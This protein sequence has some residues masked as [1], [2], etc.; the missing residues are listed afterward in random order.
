MTDF[1]AGLRQSVRRLVRTPGLTAAAILVYAL[2]IGANT[3]IFSIVYSVLLKPLPFPEPDRLVGVWQTA[4]GVNIENLNASIADYVTYREDSRT[5]A[6]SAIWSARSMSITGFQQPE[7]VDCLMATFRLLPMLGVH[8]ALG[9][10]LEEKD[11]EPGTADVILISHAYWQRRFAGDR[12]V[13]GRTI[14]ADGVRREIVGVLPPGTWLLDIGHEIVFPLRYRRS[15]VHFA[16]YNFQAIAR[17]RPG[18]TLADA[19]EDVRRM[20]ALEF[21]KFPPPPGMNLKM[22][23]DARLA[24]NLRWLRQDLTGEVSGS[25]WVVMATIGMVLLIA[26]A[27]VANLLLVRAEGRAQELTVRAALGAG[28]GHIAREL[29]MESLLLAAAGGLA[30]VAFARGALELVLRL[31]PARLPRFDQIGLD[32]TAL[33]FTFVITIAAGFGCGLP[34]LLRHLRGGLAPALRGGG[35]TLSSSRDRNLARNLLTVVQVALALM[36][37]IGSGLMIRTFL[38]MRRVQPGFDARELQTLRISIPRDAAPDAKALRQAYDRVQSRLAAIPGIT[39]TGMTSALPM[40]GQLS[41]DPVMSRDRTYRPD[42]IPPL[43]RFVTTSPGALRAMGTPLAAGREFNWTD[44]HEDRKVVLV[45]ENFAREYWG[46]A[47]EA[48]G[49]Q[50]GTHF[51][52][53]WREIIGVAADVRLDGVNKKAPSTVYW[54]LNDSRSMT[55]LLRTPQA[56]SEALTAALRSAVWEVSGSVP[57]TEMRT[58]REVYERSMARTAFTLALLGVSG[59]MALLLAAVGIYAV[60]SYNVGQRTREIGIR[61]AL[62]ARLGELKLMFVRHGVQWAGAGALAGLA[63]AAALSRLM[64]ALLFEIDPVDPL[65]YGVVAFGLLAVAGLASYLPARR[66]TRVEPVTAL[67]AD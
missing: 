32:G 15:E 21:T 39:V 43:R 51:H 1:F 31:S 49:K 41:Q 45:S 44:I 60:I 58:M 6:D 10:P 19:S 54:P 14:M 46:S 18:V 26:C 17:L 62:G 24:P 47:R 30:S 11:S 66:V 59:V 55:L 16:G 48:I 28:R 42:Q 65:T 40:T 56:G 52:T 33:A 13:I 50:I 9:R 4:P 36:L 12:Q 29:L 37:L 34:P 67:R 20:I 25:L 64:S 7:R 35:R 27:N 2:G 63:G 57:V 53:G 23:A 61:M 38:S 5:F 3:A 22:L 8:P